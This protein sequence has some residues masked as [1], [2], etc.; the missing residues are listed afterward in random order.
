M[1]K[2]I[3]FSTCDYFKNVKVMIIGDDLIVF[4]KTLSQINTF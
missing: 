2:T 1:A 3:P 4:N